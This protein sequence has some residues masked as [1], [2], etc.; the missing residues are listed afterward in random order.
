M[1]KIYNLIMKNRFDINKEEVL[2][3]HR[4][5]KTEKMMLREQSGDVKAQLQAMV[6][7]GQVPGAIKVIEMDSDNPNYKWAIK[8][9][10]KQKP[11]TFVYLF[12]DR[13]FGYFGV[14]GF[15]FGEGLWTP[16]NVIK[17]EVETVQTPDQNKPKEKT[18]N[19]SQKDALELVGNL[20][21]KHEPAISDVLVDQGVY[22]KKNLVDPKDEFGQR[23]SKYFIK[24]F[25]NG[26]FVYKKASV[27]SEVPGKVKKVEITSESC[28]TSI[29][30]LWNHLKSPNSYPLTAEEIQSYKKTAETCAEPANKQKFL[31]RFGLK[32][33]LED[34]SNS[35]IRVR[36]R[37]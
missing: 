25:P 9:E 5:Y 26:F 7:N 24:D 30:S 22:E 19:Q 12:L 15:T 33:K 2:N 37:L 16:K 32:N 28:K 11:G 36:S 13:T 20:G 17:K 27:A 35:W 31:L 21:W 10:S 4:K 3:L 8:K 14:D 34:L 29:E 6:D 1:L 18:L 23:Y